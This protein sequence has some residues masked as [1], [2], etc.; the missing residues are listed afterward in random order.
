MGDI[1]YVNFDKIKSKSTTDSVREKVY[2]TIESFYGLQMTDEN[3]DR[4]LIEEQNFERLLNVMNIDSLLASPIANDAVVDLAK[5]IFTIRIMFRQ[6]KYQCMVAT[7][8]TDAFADARL[9]DKIIKEWTES[10]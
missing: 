7:N 3:Y 4:L 2:K 1:V 6:L 8:K 10:K 9:S 5:D